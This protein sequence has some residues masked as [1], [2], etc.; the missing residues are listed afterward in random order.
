MEPKKKCKEEKKRKKK[1]KT[2]GE[3]ARGGR[4][5]LTETDVQ[6]AKERSRSRRNERASG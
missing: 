5:K 2:D 6:R 1:R 4:E 3:E